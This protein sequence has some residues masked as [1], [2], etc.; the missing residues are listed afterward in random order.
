MR[1]L[2]ELVEGR[3]VKELLS[4]LPKYAERDN[5]FGY[6]L[7]AAFVRYNF[8]SPEF[9]NLSFPAGFSAA[10]LSIGIGQEPVGL[11]RP[12]LISDN[13]GLVSIVL[14]GSVPLTYCDYVPHYNDVPK[15]DDVMRQLTGYNSDGSVMAHAS[16]RENGI[17]VLGRE[18]GE[19]H[20][21]DVM[22]WTPS[23]KVAISQFNS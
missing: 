1:M 17:Y 3:F 14:N 22:L 21:H 20:R 18:G 4:A 12:V 23:G 7:L 11:R 6:S 16:L 10:S 5:I 13:S 2:D 19:Q 15:G 9:K 8:H